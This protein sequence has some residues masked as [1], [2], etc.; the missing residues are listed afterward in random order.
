MLTDNSA[1][2]SRGYTMG[3]QPAGATQWLSA[4]RGYTMRPAGASQQG[5]HNAAR[6]YT[7]VLSQ[8]GLHIVHMYLL[9]ACT[10]Q[11]T[12]A[13]AAAAGGCGCGAC[14]HAVRACMHAVRACMRCGACMRACVHA[15]GWLALLARTAPAAATYVGACSGGRT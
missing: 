4:S 12:V 6:G 13:A 15:C 5:L 11:R 14:M 2:A 3:S 9:L 7:M 1:R 8:Q 10:Q